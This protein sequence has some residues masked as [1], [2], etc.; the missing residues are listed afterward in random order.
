VAGV[1]VPVVA[2][3]AGVLLTG[4]GLQVLTLDPR[5]P[6]VTSAGRLRPDVLRLP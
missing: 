6:T 1:V 3:G 2:P 4:T 5:W